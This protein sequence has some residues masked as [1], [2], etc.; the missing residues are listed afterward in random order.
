VTVVTGRD[1]PDTPAIRAAEAAGPHGISLRLDADDL[2]AAVDAT[3]A[4]LT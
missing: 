1:R 2:L 4:D 3:V